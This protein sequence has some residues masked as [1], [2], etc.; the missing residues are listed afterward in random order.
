LLE[1][2]KERYLQFQRSGDLLNEQVRAGPEFPWVAFDIREN[3]AGTVAN[4]SGA[5]QPAPGVSYLLTI[6]K[7]KLAPKPGVFFSV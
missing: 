4:P 3:R 1:R 5:R 7:S 2:K 6:S